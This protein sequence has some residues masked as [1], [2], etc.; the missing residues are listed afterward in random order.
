MLEQRRRK[1]TISQKII[2]FFG[3][4]ISLIYKNINSEYERSIIRGK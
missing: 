4:K 3:L 1:E 2:N